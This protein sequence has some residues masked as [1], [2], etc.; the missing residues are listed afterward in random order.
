MSARA[1]VGVGSNLDDPVVHVREAMTALDQLPLT[2]VV[3]CASLY[4]SAP[5][6]K[7]DQPDFIN[8]VA[9]LDTQLAPEPLLDALLAVEA[10]HGRVRG[11]R[12]APRTLDLDL[13]LYGTQRMHG[14]HLTLPHPRMHER[15]F[16][17]LP[18][19]EIDPDAL[20]PG[21][22][23]VRALLPQVADQRVVRMED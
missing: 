15:A 13:L 23:S 11:E 17:L 10:R 9:A 2:R 3:C 1:Y 22:G 14:A 4:R 6:G 18:L 16:V 8:S 7:L 20:I 5:V 19:A 21:H 12:N